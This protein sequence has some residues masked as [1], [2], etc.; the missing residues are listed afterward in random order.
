[1]NEALLV[2]WIWRIYE[3][4]EN[5]V[6]CKLLRKKYLGDKPFSLAKSVGMSQ[7]WQGLPE[8]KHQFD[9]GA[10]FQVHNGKSTM[11]WDDVWIHNVPLRVSYPKIYP[12][13]RNRKCLVSD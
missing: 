10:I 6:C 3:N 1:M 7:F 13:C 8:V 5:D 2:K 12:I 4:D 9:K 11:F